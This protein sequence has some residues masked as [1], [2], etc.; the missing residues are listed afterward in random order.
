MEVKDGV[1]GIPFDSFLQEGNCAAIKLPLVV[2]PI[3]MSV[4]AAVDLQLVPM[5]IV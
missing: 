1:S 2:S 5:L 4:I 3:T